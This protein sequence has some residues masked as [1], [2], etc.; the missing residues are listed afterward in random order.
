MVNEEKIRTM[1][2]LASYEKS[3]SEKEQKEGG[4][5]RS[6]Y[7]R[8][9]LLVTIWSYSVAYL[10]LLALVALYHFDYLV[11]AAD[12]W[13]MRSLILV[14]VAVYIL[15]ILGCVYF[16]ITAASRKYNQLQKKRKEYY[17]ELKKLEAVY[18]QSREE[19]NG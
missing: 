13:Q 16:T 17:H 5:Y 3:M 18:R 4:Y 9:H 7:I 12:I 15:L 11:S 10:F 19:G 8:S 1:T 2:R 14:V 6:D